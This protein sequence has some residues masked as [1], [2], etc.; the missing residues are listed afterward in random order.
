MADSKMN[1]GC[2]GYHKDLN[3]D[4]HIVEIVF[5]LENFHVASEPHHNHFQCL[6]TEY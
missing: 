6:D 5:V 2:L 3:L 4:F 1:K